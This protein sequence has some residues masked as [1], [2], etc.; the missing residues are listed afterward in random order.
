MA[1]IKS[2]SCGGLTLAMALAYPAAAQ[3]QEA[4]GGG[5]DMGAEQAG[6]ADI[7]VTAQRREQ[8][9]QDVPISATV[10]SGADLQRTSQT[11]LEDVTSRLPNV[12]ISTAPA[13]DFL[14]VRGVGSS[15]NLGFEQAVATFVD[16]LYR[17]RARAS[18]VALFDIQQIEILKGPQTTFFG[19]NAIAGA[20]NITTRKPGREFEANA[21][22]YYA[23]QGDEYSLEAGVSVPLTDTLSARVAGRLSGQKGYIYNDYLDRYGPN[24]DSKQGRISLAWEPSDNLTV[25]ARLDV[26]QLRDQDMFN[27][28]LI[29]CPPDPAF[30]GPRGSCQRYLSANGGDVDD[31]LDRRTA[32]SSSYFNYDFYEAYLS[33][34]IS[35]AD[36]ILTLTTGLYDHDYDIFNDPATIV[37]ELGGSVVGTTTT[38]PSIGREQFS[39]VSQ[40]VRFQSDSG[41]TV[42][43]MAGIYYAHTKARF[44]NY[45]GRYLA[46]FGSFSGGALPN[47]AKVATL[48]R[49]RETSDTMSIFGSA[50]VHFSPQFRLNLGARYSIVDKDANR[51]AV[52]GTADS[53]PGPDNFVSYPELNSILLP[54]TG[55]DV[56]NYDFTS[57]SDNKFMP[58]V[59]VQYDITD[60]VMTYASYTKGFKAGGFAVAVSK[61]T[62]DPETVD[63]FEVGLKSNLFDRRLTFNIAAF[64]SKYKSLQETITL[65][66]P[67]GST[68]Q[69]VSNVAGTEVKGVELS[70]MLRASS[71]LT[72]SADVAYLDSRYTNHPTAPCTPLQNLFTTP[73]T[74]DMTGKQRPF[75]PKFSGNVGARFSQPVGESIVLRL[76][77]NIYFTSKFFQQPNAD[78]FMSQDGFAKV[79]ARIGLGADNGRW[80]VAIIGK[81]LTDKLTASFRQ[82]VP[83]APG[84]F[85]ALAEQGRTIGFQL[86]MR[87]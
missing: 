16:G 44:F 86:S 58:A 38:L 57:R 42:D 11:N 25:N 54:V 1:K 3:A 84:S 77:G 7:I 49:N 2:I 32:A 15:L 81:N 31:T 41:G 74:Q 69:V 87:Y 18:R 26:G 14:N 68:A 73:C 36:H 64:L 70:T 30:G 24:L 72:L 83:G 63:A 33:A 6:P 62:F 82:T 76:D 75:A 48:T 40:E 28:E 52:V 47:N 34:S 27:V 45:I 59:N 43:Y 22:V 51:T 8:R 19:N 29:D 50:T 67:G 53:M 78:P 37:G 46:P 20:L 39:Q 61:A 9:L 60:D 21:L 55:T 13:S 35:V 85:Q 71:Q 66:L 17:G 5:A 12:K 56:G 80:E 79:D 65:I 10:T 4:A 23:P